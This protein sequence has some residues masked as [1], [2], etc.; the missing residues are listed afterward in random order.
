MSNGKPTVII[1]TVN[2][3][4]DKNNSRNEWIFYKNR[5]LYVK[6]ELELSHYAT[7]SDLK[8]QRVFIHWILLKKTYLAHLKS[9]IDKLDIDK[10]K[11]VPSG[12][13]NLKSKVSKL[14]VGKLIPVPFYLIKLSDAVKNDAV[15]NTEY[16]ELV[17]K[18]NNMNTIDT[19]NWV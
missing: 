18:V 15:K 11:N 19:S 8:M 1:S 16:N 7:K 12:L 14:D 4:I 6:V 9:D 3:W 5:N 17:K 13:N 2:S 10:L